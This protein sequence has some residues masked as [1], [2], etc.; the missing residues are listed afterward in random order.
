ME[1][2]RVGGDDENGPNRRV[3]R[4]L[5]IGMCFLLFLSCILDSNQWFSFYLG[6]MNVFKE[7]GGWVG[8]CRQKRAQMT[9]L[10]SFGL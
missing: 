8:W 7:R 6:S 1:E 10:A 3:G 2:A 9:H 5:A 4:R